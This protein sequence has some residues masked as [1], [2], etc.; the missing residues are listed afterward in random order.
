MEKSTS[1]TQQLLDQ[2]AIGWL[3]FGAA[4]QN[5]KRA[6]NVGP[7]WQSKIIQLAEVNESEFLH[8]FTR[9]RAGSWPD[10]SESNYFDELLFG[11]STG[12]HDILATLMRIVVMKRILAS[13]KT[14]RSKH[15]VCSFTQV[16]LS[17]FDSLRRFRP[18]LSRW[19]FLP[20]GISIRKKILE[21]LGARPVIYGDEDKWQSLAVADQPFFHPNLTVSKTG[22]ENVWSVEREWR[23]LS[24]VDFSQLDTRD[25]FVFVADE[26][27]AQAI[28][29]ATHF[30]VVLTPAKTS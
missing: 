30:P 25:C 7:R 22:N 29:T 28:A 24:D 23:L 21:D 16:P 2:G 6:S 12:N 17:D 26:Q 5:D 27:S 10:Q 13:S 4:T 9:P 14:T 11:D 19:D 3:L 18:H 1:E 8:H 15:K 20:F